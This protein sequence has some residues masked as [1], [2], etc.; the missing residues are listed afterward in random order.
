MDINIKNTNKTSSL[1][2]KT[3]KIN[4]ETSVFWAELTTDKN[5]KK[6]VEHSEGVASVYHLNAATDA[7]HLPKHLSQ[8]H[9]ATPE[10]LECIRV[11]GHPGSLK[12][13]RSRES[14]V[15]FKIMS[16]CIKGASV[17]FL[18]CDEEKIKT[19]VKVDLLSRTVVNAVSGKPHNVAIYSDMLK[20]SKE[21]YNDFPFV[22]KKLIEDGRI[23][24]RGY[25]T[26]FTHKEGARFLPV[27]IA[28]TD[29]EFE[30]LL[31]F[32]LNSKGLVDRFLFCS[33]FEK[34]D[35]LGINSFLKGDSI[36]ECENYAV[37]KSCCIP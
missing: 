11:H 37:P 13:N 20:I 10:Y 27:P 4:N 18:D 36:M 33:G 24:E 9:Y 14:A 34:F 12:P 16:T 22:I 28:I 5:G 3:K 35:L 6:Y 8:Y 32:V 30:A 25:A 19:L 7:C 17:S 2:L 31:P 26:F 23:A 1:Q 15:A 21:R 29:K